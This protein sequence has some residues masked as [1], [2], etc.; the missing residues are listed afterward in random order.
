MNRNRW[1]QLP[2]PNE[3]IDCVHHMARQEKANRSLIFQN[4]NRE[5]LSD[6]NDD[7]DDESYSPSATDEATEY[8]LLEPV[9]D[10]DDHMETQGVD[11]LAEL[12]P[13][14]IGNGA[15]PPDTHAGPEQGVLGVEAP[16]DTTVPPMGPD[17]TNLITE[18][19]LEVTAEPQVAPE[20]T[21]TT[22]PPPPPPPP[23]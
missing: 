15:P 6:Q 1:T 8:E 22:T 23:R 16:N 12:E 2:M 10:D 21:A 18:P 5:L 13:N 7:D 9:D 11:T 14:M 19:A 20:V 3:V 4:R 17:T